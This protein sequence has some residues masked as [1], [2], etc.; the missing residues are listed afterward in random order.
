MKFFEE[1]LNKRRSIAEIYNINLP[2]EVRSV[3]TDHRSSNYYCYQTIAQKRD[4][5]MHFLDEKGIESKIRHHFLIPDNKPFKGFPGIYPKATA[6]KNLTLCLPI[7]H[8]MTQEDAIRICH[9]INNFY[10]VK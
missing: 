4:S 6:Y 1:K 5:L 2:E 10:R 7:H 3:T 8:N 9:E